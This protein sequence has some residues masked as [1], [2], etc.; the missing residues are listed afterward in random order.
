MKYI[1]F[2]SLFA[3]ALLCAATT[4]HAA[5]YYVDASRPDDSGDG[6]APATAKKTIQ[7]A[8]DLASDEDVIRVASGSYAP[9]ASANKRLSI[10]AETPDVVIDGGGT[11]RCATLNLANDP[12]ATNTVL[13]GFALRNGKVTGEGNCGGG[14]RGGT[15][16]NC[17]ISNCHSNFAGGGAALSTLNNSVLT[18]NSSPGSGGGAYISTLNNCILTG[19]TASLGGGGSALCTLNNCLLVGN[20][21]AR[22]GGST[23]DIL[24]NCTVYGNI[25]DEYAG[26]CCFSTVNNCIVWGNTNVSALSEDNHHMITAEYSCTT[27][28]FQISTNGDNTF[29]FT[30]PLFVD[31]ANGDFRL[32]KGS[33][34]IGAGNIGYVEVAN[35]MNGTL[36]VENG[37]VNMGAFAGMVSSSDYYVD[38]SRPDDSGDG[39]SWAYAKQTIQ[40]A[41]DL[42]DEGVTIYVAP[43]IYSPITTENKRISITASAP[44]TIIDGGGINRCAMLGASAGETNTVMTGF[45]LQNGF[46]PGNGGGVYGGTLSNCTLSAN[47]AGQSG[48]GAFGSL[49]IQC[50]IYQNE[51]VEGGGAHSAT[52]FDA[53]AMHNTASLDGGFAH[54]CVVTE[55]ILSSNVA[56]Y[57]GGAV[58]SSIVSN[59]TLT[60]N[61]AGQHG[62]AAFD[63][64]LVGCTIQ[65]NEAG[66][67]GGAASGGSLENCL[68]VNNTA[69]VNGGGTHDA[70]LI[71]C[72]LASNTAQ[73]GG[74]VYGGLLNNTVL[75]ENTANQGGGAHGATL[76][77]CAVT[78]NTADESGGICASDAANTI[79]WINFL[80]ESSQESNYENST[81]AYSCTAPLPP[82]EGNISADPRF[83]GASDFRL[84]QDS[85]CIGAGSIAFV[86]VEVDR[87]GHPVISDGRANMG[88]FAG[89]L[90]VPVTS[91]GV[92]YAWLDGYGLVTDGDYEAAALSDPSGKGYPAWRDYI[93]GTNPL[94]SLDRFTALIEATGGEAQITWQPDL[95]PD[96]VY[97]IWGKTNLTNGVEWGNRDP[98]HRFFKVTVELKE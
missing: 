93:A 23:I 32:K 46:T 4:L 45:T 58:Y 89:S 82:G 50:G 30:D 34:C 33:P 48:G 85:P 36:M 56:D 90:P 10:I 18:N 88:A 16:N 25:A 95:T 59:A 49:L 77:N 28:L 35:D 62:G 20:S 63:S 54:S 53:W 60:V 3:V 1:I 61:S 71:N 37:H 66:E 47:T 67:N 14:V 7:A 15:L 74:G 55:G 2:K 91:Q 92:P 6:T 78:R 26:G 57:D 41:I 29:V 70:A 8:I 98:G 43:G 44:G 80:T 24:N 42:A 39:S 31:A 86:Q 69:G 94:D 73:N 5:T 75:A 52:L 13:I 19:N 38:A 79:V 72:T 84:W 12:T 22:G 17:I 97:T 21:G 40:S 51:A 87:F 27:P 64:S 11:N 96:R 65:I 68:V 83:V 9:I 81:F 76:I